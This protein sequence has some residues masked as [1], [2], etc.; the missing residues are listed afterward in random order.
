MIT[1][2]GRVMRSTTL[3]LN[4]SLKYL[5]NNNNTFLLHTEFSQLL[6]LKA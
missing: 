4:Q 5:L 3:F 1:L 2:R 6:Q